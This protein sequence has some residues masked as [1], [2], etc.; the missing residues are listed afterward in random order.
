MCV[1]FTL[2]PKTSELTSDSAGQVKVDLDGA[3]GKAKIVVHAGPEPQEFELSVSGLDPVETLAG[4][5]ARCNQLGHYCGVV[6]GMNGRNTRNG[7]MEFQ[8]KHGLNVDGVA[9]PMTEGK[10]EEAYGL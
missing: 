3:V 2:V 8:K 9:G 1:G 5:Q 6:D 10:L 7:I 4:I